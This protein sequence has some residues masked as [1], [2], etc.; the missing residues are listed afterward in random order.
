[1]SQK[2]TPARPPAYSTSPPTKRHKSLTA[3]LRAQRARELEQ[4]EEDEAL[5]A[6]A[7]AAGLRGGGEEGDGGEGSAGD[8]QLAEDFYDE[9]GFTDEDVSNMDDDEVKIEEESFVTQPTQQLTHVPEIITA[10]ERF[11]AETR[12][13]I[14]AAA[15]ALLGAGSS[16]ADEDRT[17]Q[18]ETRSRAKRL[19]L[20]ASTAPAKLSAKKPN[21]T[22][23]KQTKQVKQVKQ[24]K[25]AKQAKESTRKSSGKQKQQQQQMESERPIKLKVN[26]GSQTKGAHKV[27]KPAGRAAKPP[28]PSPKQSPARSESPSIPSS[29]PPPLPEPPVRFQ[30]T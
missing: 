24:V 20:A 26:M 2:R 1:M 14:E 23:T 9:H 7:L 30:T 13:G 15:T 8:S 10:R 11:V 27:S 18:M 28:A 25:Q 22:Q 6:E 12:D 17:L 19:N 4:R 5:A 3:I 16:A 29:P 21:S